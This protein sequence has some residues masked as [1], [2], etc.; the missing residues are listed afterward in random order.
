M[1]RRIDSLVP[2]PVQA[3]AL[4]AAA[5]LTV[6]QLR[7]ELVY[8]SHAGSE[9]AAQGHAYLG[10]LM[11][12]VAMGLAAAAGLFIVELG[13]AN[14]GR[15]RRP[16]GLSLPLLWALASLALLAIYSSQELGEGFLASGHPGGLVGVFGHGGLIAVP[17]SLVL[18]AVVA[19]CLRGADAVVTWVASR[20]RARRSRRRPVSF[21]RP[22]DAP[23]FASAPLAA[24]AAGRAP[25]PPLAAAF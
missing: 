23:R 17:L 6:H 16:R 19:M 11:P 15:S 14:V 22:L 7:Y 25:P 21:S 4:M 20:A 2:R 1:R 9:L 12:L 13:Q 18:G 24:S 3:A 8:G 5:V 10:F